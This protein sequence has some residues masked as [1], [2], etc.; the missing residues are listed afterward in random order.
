[1][2]FRSVASLHRLPRILVLLLL[3]L[4]ASPPF[5]ASDAAP[6]KLMSE[7]LQEGMVELRDS[8]WRYRFGDDANW[9]AKDYDDSAW[10]TT[11]FDKSVL[12]P[13]NSSGEGWNGA[14]WFRLRLEVDERLAG[15]PLALRIYHWGAS[16]IYV[17][18]RLV[19]SF[20][21]IGAEEDKE[22]NPRGVPVPFVFREGGAH[23]IAIR[24]SYKAA[25]DLTSGAGHFLEN[26][27]ML[28][29]FNAFIQP[30]GAAAASYGRNVGDSRSN[31]L[32]IGILVALAL[33]H[34]LLY[35]FYR[36]E[37]ANLFYSIF[38]LSLAATLPLNNAFNG[39]DPYG[40][41]SAFVA[42]VCFVGFVC[43]FAVVFSSLL[44]FLHVAFG[45]RFTKRF[46]LLLALWLGVMVMT[47]I[48]VRE[49]ATLYI[50]SL[51]LVLTLVEAIIIMVRVL[52]GRR[53]GA[54]IIMAGLLLF[55]FA[56]SATVGRELVGFRPPAAFWEVVQL[57]ILL[58]V[59]VSVSIFLARNF[60]RTNFN[61]EAQLANVKDL[62]ARQ[63]EHERTEAKLRLQHEKEKAE[64]A[65]RAQ[66]LEEARSL[67][68]SM[69]PKSVP[70]LP[71]FDIAA[72]MKPATEVGGDYYDFH[73]A[74]DGTL[75]IVVGDATG[76]GLKAG[77][78]VTATKSLFNAFADEPDIRTFFRK[79]SHALKSMN[80]RGL[81]MAMT[82]LK[83]RGVR[84]EVS[85]AG[86]PALLIY[87]AAENRV[88]EL[89]IS[90]MPLGSLVT[91]PYKQHGFE[92][93]AG[94]ALMLMSDGFPEMFNEQ[95]EM[96]D[97][98]RA[99]AVLA[100]V[101]HENSN[102]IIERFVREGD[103]WAGMRPQDDDVT[104]VVV[105]VKQT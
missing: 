49:Y 24:Y 100:E 51:S 33:L 18:G 76:H 56:M 8:A 34:F 89:L 54:W 92:L 7:D 50:V 105:K 103:E 58:A 44:A 63:L 86:M 40:A 66:E 52:V 104:F 48:Y 60:A 38:A 2:K 39:D 72:Y 47:A 26:A 53:E 94:D 9:A 69:L 11:G 71:H 84:V 3:L 88:E 80:L 15:V 21:V 27:K 12:K 16:D 95:N 75:T 61:L 23:S 55:A 31:R 83:I 97:Y 10:A 59:P 99:R 45:V 29:G 68:L 32:F 98:G 93:N 13:K 74:P 35:V 87:R 19:K 57:L 36:R 20:G 37:R 77:T 62:S 96:L 90:G 65:R 67:Q 102:E 17:D 85:A 73:V 91:F 22:F 42:A 28:P 43:A 82:M 1:M 64:N 101:A 5:R 79:A 78:V 70:Q 4:I 41:R 6:L 46:W 14:A 25:R 30:A 81:F